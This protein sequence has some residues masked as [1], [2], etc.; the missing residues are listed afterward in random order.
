M[1]KILVPT[2]CSDLSRHAL[3][4]AAQISSKTGAEIY[5]LRVC[6]VPPE[7]IFG[8]EGMVMQ[9]EA[10]DEQILD[11]EIR[12]ASEELGNW[13]VKEPTEVTQFVECGAFPEVV[14]AFINKKE[15][16]L[17][18]MA[19]QGASGLKEMIIGSHAEKIVRLSEA[20][21][22]TIK[23]A[24]NELQVRNIVLAGDFAEGGSAGLE[25]LLQIRE[26]F[27][28]KL[29]LL[30]INT[31]NHFETTRSVHEWMDQFVSAH[32]LQNVQKHI[33]CDTHVESGIANFAVDHEIDLI[34]IGTHGR[35]GIRHLLFGSLSEDLVNHL[36]QPVLTF[37]LSENG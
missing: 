25:T 11:A 3:R 19:S 22:L 29:H 35:T 8:T 34:A 9:N 13:L 31:P 27:S 16:D 14:E 6:E 37:R 1:K 23:G 28:A 17:V 36:N 32:G 26:S 10:I 2:D 7:V 4:L 5:A 12:R 18:I 21:V 33:Y 24:Q 20:P 15:I 30:R